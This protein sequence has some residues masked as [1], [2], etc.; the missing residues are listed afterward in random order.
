MEALLVT[1]HQEL[2]LSGNRAFQKPVIVVMDKYPRARTL[3]LTRVVRLSISASASRTRDSVHPKVSASTMRNSR[4]I[5]L[6][7]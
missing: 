6:E 5:A 1:G 4:R 3:D 7:I 2:G